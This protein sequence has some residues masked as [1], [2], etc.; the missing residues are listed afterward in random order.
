MRLDNTKT[1]YQHKLILL[2]Q[3]CVDLKS[4]KLEE[5]IVLNARNEVK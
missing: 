1:Q 2:T 3:Q 5:A 4:W